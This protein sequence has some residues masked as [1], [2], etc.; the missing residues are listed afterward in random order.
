M[1]YNYYV[2]ILQTQYCLHLV[3]LGT[4]HTENSIQQQMFLVFCAKFPT[5][6]TF[7][8][9][10]LNTN[11]ALLIGYN[12]E[13]YVSLNVYTIQ[14]CS[15]QVHAATKY[16]HFVHEMLTCLISDEGAKWLS[17]E[18]LGDKMKKERSN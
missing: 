12:M 18:T 1:Y 16:S 5:H 9:C 15:L 14:T 7:I 8:K 17:T 11:I 10:L 6:L 4:A 13:D 3:E 2:H